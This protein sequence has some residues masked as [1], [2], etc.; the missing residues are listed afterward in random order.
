MSKDKKKKSLRNQTFSE[1]N[2]GVFDVRSHDFRPTQSAE[3]ALVCF[4]SSLRRLFRLIRPTET[5]RSD[6]MSSVLSYR[7]NK[8]EFSRPI[9]KSAMTYLTRRKIVSLLIFYRARA[10]LQMVVE[11]GVSGRS[12]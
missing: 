2:N 7:P 9:L 8:Q 1:C 3:K 6:V 5:T 10:Q 11:N 4:L 12:R